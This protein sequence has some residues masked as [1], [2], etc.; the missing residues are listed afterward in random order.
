RMLLVCARI[1]PLML[2]LEDLQWVDGGALRLLEHLSVELPGAPVL[3]AISVREEAREPSHRVLRTLAHLRQQPSCEAIDLGGLSRGE[4][5]E[6]L[7]IAVGGPVPVDLVSELY[8]RTEGVP[9][10]VGE[11]IRLLEERGDLDRPE[12][13]PRDGIMLPARA[14]DLIRRSVEAISSECGAL[15]GAAAVIG[16]DFPLGL[17]T[18]VAGLGAEEAL[19]LVD[20]ATRAGL[21]E[22]VE[23]TGAITHRFTHALF[24]EAVYAGLSSR[25]RARLHQVVA[26]RLEQ[27]HGG[28]LDSVASE[29]AHHHHR[30]LPVGDPQAAFASAIRAARQARRLFAWEQAALHQAQAMAAL[31]HF[32]AVDP[33]IRAETLLGLGEAHALSGHRTRRMAAYEQ[34]VDVSRSMGDVEL[35]VEAAIGLCDV[36]EWSSHSHADAETILRDTLD[37]VDKDDLLARSRLVA[38][39]AYLCV[40]DRDR[41]EA[42]AREAVAFARE[43]GSA[44]ALQESLYILH[45]A[46]AG[47]DD[48]AEREA[49]VSELSRSA[50]AGGAREADVIAALDLACDG[51]MQGDLEKARRHRTLAS[52]LVGRHASPSMTWHMRVWDA[53]LDLLEGR[54]AQAEQ[55]AHDALL[56]GRRL[57][58]PF[59]SACFSGQLSL[60]QRETSRLGELVDR[61]EGRTDHPAGASH[62][63]KAVLGRALRDL[64]QDDRARAVW[65]DLG[66]Q[67]FAA[68]NRGIRW[69]ATILE[70]SMLTAELGE[71]TLARPLLDQLSSAPEQHAVLPI[72]IL[73]GGPL[74]HAMAA[75]SLLL[76]LSDEAM[77]LYDDAIGSASSLG[78]RPTVAHLLIEAAPLHART[79][80]VARAIGMARDAER[81]SEELGMEPAEAAARAIRTKLEHRPSNG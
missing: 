24:Q 22:T 51:L 13:I 42:L 9:L 6:L 69:N 60:I 21:I 78:A 5:G 11:A 37:R 76:G 1:R 47:P 25:T 50:R 48:L 63:A 46:I 79:G 33:R 10:F 66:S 35:Q 75:L 53:G 20:E 2:V 28:A 3:L 44:I 45:Y 32:E 23:D 43:C 59:A 18:S 54:F 15:L 81:L 64:G 74:T 26:E 70:V 16:R 73:Y 12:R 19:D 38:R 52:E 31:E 55:A 71:E 58:H 72:P 7:R 68:L 34:A 67:G 77:A 65:E 4:V 61:L 40:R 56:L 17:A 39:L 27:R 8:G 29:L 49:L 14:I 80:S 57:G 36:S 30:A 62:W 41:S